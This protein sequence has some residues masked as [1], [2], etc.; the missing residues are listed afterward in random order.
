MPIEGLLEL[1]YVADVI[2]A[3]SFCWACVNSSREHSFGP[4]SEVRRR[5]VSNSTIGKRDF[6]R[7]SFAAAAAFAMEARSGFG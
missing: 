2:G 3:L 4:L 6:Q 5:N 1:S 7:I